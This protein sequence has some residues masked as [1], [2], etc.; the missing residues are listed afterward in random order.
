MPYWHTARAELK[1]QH[2]SAG[3]SVVLF[4][5]WIRIAATSKG[6]SCIYNPGCSLGVRQW[7]NYYKKKMRQFQMVVLLCLIQKLFAPF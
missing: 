1:A 4:V 3:S 7:Q 2:G 5:S 6:N